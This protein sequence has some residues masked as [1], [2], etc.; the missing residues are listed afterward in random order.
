MN[1]KKP[2][3]NC[4]NCGK[5]CHRVKA[6]YCSAQ[7]RNDYI[8][9]RYIKEWLEGKNDGSKKSGKAGIYP[10]GHVMRYLLEQS[11]EA[12]EIC[13]WNKKHSVSK[14]TLVQTHHIDGNRENNKR[15][16]LK[17]LCPNCHSLTTT[18]MNHGNRRDKQ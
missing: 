11:K 15:D 5:E 12:C 3:N 7:C 2:R 6:I 1:P 4:L 18:W 17:V 16:N 14:R 9:D 8:Y 10:S 13:G